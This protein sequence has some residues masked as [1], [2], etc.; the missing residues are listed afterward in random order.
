MKTGK[1]ITDIIKSRI[2]VRNYQSSPLDENTKSKIEN[3][4]NE[5]GSGPFGGRVRFV[6]TENKTIAGKIIGTYGMITGAENYIAGA[7]K[8]SKRDLEDFGYA[9]EKLIL[10]ITEGGLGTCWLGGAIDRKEFKGLINLRDD[11]I[12]PAATPVGH[13]YKSRNIREKIV[14]WVINAKK[15]KP[16]SEMFF[17]TQY[18]V[19]LAENEAGKYKVPVEMVR[20]AP[21]ASNKQPWRIIKEN[22]SWHFYLERNAAYQIRMK[23]IGFDLQRVDMGIALCHFELTCNE[24]GLKGKWKLCDVKH[25]VVPDNAEYITSWVED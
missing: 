14:R 4:F 9:M 11:E 19:P 6:L 20:L 13:F 25:I 10:L 15:R 12:I 8:E 22:N 16:W 5:C 24:L 21:S 1:F 2:S 3:F 18:N 7:I 17:N 23:A